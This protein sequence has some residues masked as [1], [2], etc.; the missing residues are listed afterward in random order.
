MDDAPYAIAD[1]RQSL[2]LRLS[3][4]F[5]LSIAAASMVA[6]PAIAVEQLR[7][8]FSQTLHGHGDAF[9]VLY[10]KVTHQNRA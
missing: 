3:L 2:A 7:V 8:Y 1:K 9:K 4:R 5:S 6:E 10:T